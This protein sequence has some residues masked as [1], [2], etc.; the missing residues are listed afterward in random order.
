MS[1]IT[2]EKPAFHKIRVNGT[3][4]Q[5][6]QRGWSRI[7]SIVRRPFWKQCLK[8]APGNVYKHCSGTEQASNSRTWSCLVAALWVCSCKRALAW[9]RKQSITIWGRQIIE[10]KWQLYLGQKNTRWIAI[11]SEWYH[12]TRHG[13]CILEKSTLSANIWAWRK[14]LT[15]FAQSFLS[16]FKP[17]FVLSEA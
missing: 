11:S 8:D 2:R 10:S 1:P 15:N 13:T 5:L 4:N 14:L 7:R 3:W 12:Q 17:M 6:S 9:H 16:T